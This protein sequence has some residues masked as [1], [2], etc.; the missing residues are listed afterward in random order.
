MPSWIEFRLAVQGL[1]RLARFNP[2]FPRFFDRSG[3]G[4]L[5]SFWL[6]VPLFPF[7]LL[8]LWNSDALSHTADSTQFFLAM[9]VGYVILWLVPPLLITL[10]APMM[11]REA[12]MPGCITV[13]NWSG[14]LNIG[15]ALP[16]ILLD[17]VGVSPDLMSI[18][19]NVL[20]LVTLVWE[21]FLLTHTLRVPLWQAAIATAGDYFITHWVLISIF[22]VLGGVSYS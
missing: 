10:I 15:V 13:Y 2:D 17:L 20:L 11:G 14:V 5:R 9:S 12:E 21:A 8:Q 16:L 1:L 6:M 3:A 4:A 19:Y 22:L 18:P 7:Y